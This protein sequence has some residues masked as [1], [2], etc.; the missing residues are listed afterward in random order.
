M[1]DD[2]E[3]I[4]KTVGG[5]EESSKGDDY[6]GEG[7]E[8]EGGASLENTSDDDNIYGAIASGQ[9]STTSHAKAVMTEI[10]AWW[11]YRSMGMSNGTHGGRSRINNGE[12]HILSRAS[13]RRY[14]LRL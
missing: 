7:E 13:Y 6:V 4:H 12:G 9:G 5:D 1:D 3:R 11:E 8:R 2:I 14:L 10:G